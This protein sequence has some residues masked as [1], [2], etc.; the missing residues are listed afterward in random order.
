[1]RPCR[2]YSSQ[3]SVV[4]SPTYASLGVPLPRLQASLTLAPFCLLSTLGNRSLWLNHFFHAQLATI[5]TIWL[6][7]HESLLKL[8][9]RL[10]STWQLLL[11]QRMHA[12]NKS[13]PFAWYCSYES[14]SALP[15]ILIYSSCRCAVASS[16]LTSST[17]PSAG[18]GTG[19]LHHLGGK[20]MPANARKSLR[21][22]MT[23]QIH[24]Q[25]PSTFG[26][27]LRPFSCLRGGP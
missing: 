17:Q 13:L 18:V 20:Q 9:T 22:N 26:A 1:M 15:V 21:S 19:A 23:S 14:R 3:A 8:K 6:T 10:A 7:M 16:F 24:I 27:L 11:G 2:W 4:I 5:S 12:A 25:N